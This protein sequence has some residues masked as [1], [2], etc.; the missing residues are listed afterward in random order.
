MA[1]RVI[2]NYS[3]WASIQF[4]LYWPEIFSFNS[5]PLVLVLFAVD[6][7]SKLNPFSMW[8]LFSFQVFFSTSYTLMCFNVL[9]SFSLLKFLSCCVHKLNLSILT[10]I[11]WDSI[12]ILSIGLRLRKM[13]LSEMSRKMSTETISGSCQALSHDTSPTTFYAA[14]FLGSLL[15]GLWL[16][17]CLYCCCCCLVTK[18]CLLFVTAWTEAGKA[19]LPMGFPRQEYW[20]GLLFPSLGIFPIQGSNLYLQLLLLLLSRFSR[21]WLCATP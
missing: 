7:Q 13:K 16:H 3:F 14:H 4:S 5:E 1:K 21:V 19:P 9:F 18:S 20:S 2:R 6:I 17:S 8:C 11:I 12:L 15:R 10:P